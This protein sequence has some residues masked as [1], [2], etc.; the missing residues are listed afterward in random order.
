MALNGS[1]DVEGFLM[2]RTKALKIQIYP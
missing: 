2:D 1:T